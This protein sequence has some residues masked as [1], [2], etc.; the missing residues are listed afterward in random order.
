MDPDFARFA[1]AKQAQVREFAASNTVPSMVWSYFDAVRVDDWQTATNLASQLHNASGR[2]EDAPANNRIS[3]PLLTVI[4]APINEMIGASGE[5]H[6]WDSQWLHRFGREIIDSIPRGSIYFGGTDPGRFII[7]ALSESHREGKPFFTLTQNQLADEAYLGYLRKI[8]GAKLYIP[9]LEDAQG[10]F[11]KYVADA[12]QRRQDGKLRPGEDVRV[13]GDQVSVSGQAA[14]MAINALLVKTIVDKNPTRDFFLEESFP[15]DWTD[16]YLTPHGL[17]FQLHP[18]SLKEL[19]A[20]VIEKDQVYWKRMTAEMIGDWMTKQTSTKELC[21]FADKIYLDKNLEGFKGS[22]GF[23]K[24]Q[25][26]Q[27]CFSKLRCSIGGLYLWRSENTRDAEDQKNMQRAAEM[28]YRQAYALCPYSP[29][30]LFRYIRLLTDLKRPD[31]AFLLAKTS[32]RLDPKNE[33]FKQLVR[34][35]N[36]AH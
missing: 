1:A 10:A 2:Y 20:D 28:A 4:W 17:I 3:A 18:K 27:K 33:A 29:E 8:Y 5:F 22:R 21:D 25:E 16:P 7:S 6:N 32:L 31:D 19:S 26:A 35:L 14:V 15:L 9:T 24:D 11:A 30:A 12:Q 13:V 36:E 23:A 34:Q